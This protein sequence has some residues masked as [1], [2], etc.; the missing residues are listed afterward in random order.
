MRCTG[1]RSGSR[2]LHGSWRARCAIVGGGGL[3]GK[4]LRLPVALLLCLACA[5]TQAQSAIPLIGAA[6]PEAGR[7]VA[8][9][10]RACHSFEAGGEQGIGPNL[11]GVVG[12]PKGGKPDFGYSPAMRAAGGRWDYE[13]LD[14]FLAGPQDYIPGTSMPIAGITDLVTRA[15]LIAFLRSLADQPVP[16]PEVES[17]AAA[18]SATSLD[19]GG[20]PEGEGQ[21]LVYYACSACHSINLVKQ[22]RLN[23]TRWEKTLQSMVAEQGMNALP[24]E[25]Q[26]QVLDYLTAHYGVR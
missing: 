13:S 26:R 19:F 11:W 25:D 15:Q 4:A 17:E 24:A 5:Q 23:R 16:L 3:L 14:R 10:C 18:P 1:W 21:A 20:L 9:M 22:Q 12:S 7:T 2:E 8:R 6:D